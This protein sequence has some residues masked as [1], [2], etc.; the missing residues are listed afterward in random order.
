M[1]E[2]EADRGLK[3]GTIAKNIL[4][5]SWNDQHGVDRVNLLGPAPALEK[6]IDDLSANRRRSDRAQHLLP[7]DA[8]EVERR[9]KAA[10]RES[11]KVA[12]VAAGNAGSKKR[13][14]TESDAKR[15]GAKKAK[16]RSAPQK[17]RKLSEKVFVVGR[18]SKRKKADKL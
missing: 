5:A 16:V 3:E 7:V 13:E 11:K 6:E 4:V 12:S 1:M 17:K 9:N 18:S 15:R 10:I 8:D 14:R 2:D